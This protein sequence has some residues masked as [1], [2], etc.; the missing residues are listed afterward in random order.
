MDPSS[1]YIIIKWI[2]F[3]LF[4]WMFLFLCI[5]DVITQNLSAY[6]W[7]DRVFFFFMVTSAVLVLC[8]PAFRSN[9]DALYT[10]TLLLVWNWLGVRFITFYIESTLPLVSEDEL[11]ASSYPE[12]YAL[13]RPTLK[14]YIYIA[15]CL[16]LLF[17]SGYMVRGY[18]HS[19]VVKWVKSKIHLCVPVYFLSFIYVQGANFI[20]VRFD[21][22][23][24]SLES[25]LVPPVDNVTGVINTHQYGYCKFPSYAAWTNVYFRIMALIEYIVWGVMVAL[26]FYSFPRRGVPKWLFT[27]FQVAVGVTYV[28]GLFILYLMHL[29]D[30]YYSPFTCICEHGGPCTCTRSGYRMPD[31][32]TWMHCT[33]SVFFM[34]LFI[35]T[36]VTVCVRYIP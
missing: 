22:A 26:V 11:K 25:E 23:H 29:L 8:F 30:P 28:F 36:A 34:A 3:T 31:V 17:W 16:V 18:V 32:W 13:A 33:T 20:A 2:L 5:H 4:V 27:V 24:L 15:M 7:V 21:L 12:Y 10:A 1:T 6:Q 35:M 19:E 14:I 9:M